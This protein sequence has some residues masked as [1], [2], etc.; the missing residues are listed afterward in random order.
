M[1]GADL[2]LQLLPVKLQQKPSRKEAVL[3]GAV[4]KF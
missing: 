3:L 2:P 4:I 1:A